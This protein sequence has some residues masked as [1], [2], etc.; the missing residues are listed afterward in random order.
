MNAPVGGDWG[1]MAASLWNSLENE[2]SS[3]ETNSC[4]SKIEEASGRS[5]VTTTAGSGALAMQQYV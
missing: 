4:A 2:G 1:G 3:E 5:G